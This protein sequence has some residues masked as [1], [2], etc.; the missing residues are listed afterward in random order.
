MKTESPLKWILVLPA[1]LFG[2]SGCA[3][4]G[5]SVGLGAL[6]GG[7][8][9]AGGGLLA[10]PG[11]R[12]ENLFRNVVIGTAAGAAVGSV[13]G[14][15]LDSSMRSRQEDAKRT[16]HSRNNPDIDTPSTGTSGNPPKLLPARMEARWV[17]DQVRGTVYIPG[18][19]EYV[20]VES[21]RWET[22]R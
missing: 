15:A 4:Q 17:P 19:F 20:I 3:T 13:A 8:L 18:H 7:A 5:K 10:D 11:K 21:A 1:T 6:S 14:F 16:S 22:G 9:G 2:L 12:G